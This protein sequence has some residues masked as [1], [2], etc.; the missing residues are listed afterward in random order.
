MILPLF[1]ALLVG[2]V[3]A[4][5]PLQGEFLAKA[6]NRLNPIPGVPWYQ[7]MGA[8]AI[9][10]GGVVGLICQL[11]AGLWWIG[12]LEAICH[13]AIDDAKCTGKIGFNVD[14]LLHVLCKIVWIFLI[15]LMYI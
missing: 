7:A 10:H 11:A 5:Y 14:Q 8:H 2:H 6:K 12:I 9:L 13:F 1:S 4:D 15:F 3:L